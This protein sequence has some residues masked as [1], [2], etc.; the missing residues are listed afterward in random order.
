MSGIVHPQRVHSLTGKPVTGPG[1]VLWWV[2]REMRARDNWGLLHA[3]DLA[4]ERGA[5]VAACF[6]LAPS[7]LGAGRRHYDFL[8]GGLAGLHQDLA[9]LN[10]PLLIRMGE[11]GKE[12]ATLAK[13][14]S[15]SAVVTDFDPL[16]PKRAWM[17]Q[18]AR[19]L[20]GLAVHEVDA[21]NVVPCR[22]VSDKR[23]YMAR[24]IRPKITRRLH[25]FLTPLPEPEPQSVR[26]DQADS[27]L[28]DPDVLAAWLKPN[29]AVP[30]VDW[31]T[32]GPR[33]AL[34]GL[35]DFLANR[36]DRYAEHKNDPNAQAVSRLSP[37]LHF[38][39]LSA[40]R[41]A[42][43]TAD[44]GADPDS[45]RSFLE[46][47]IVRREL[48]DNFC[49]HTPDYDLASGYPA[50]ARESLALHARDR[51][52]YLYS[53][54]D[55]VNAATHDPLWNAAQH[56]MAATGHMHGWLR[57]YWAKKILEWS[58]SPEAAQERCVRLNDHWSLDGRDS[59]GYAGIAWALGGVHD[60]AWKERPVFGKVRYMN[61]RGAK[62]KFD[63]DAFAAKWG[64]N[65]SWTGPRP[66]A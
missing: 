28:P 56:Q 24:T 63:V 3:L 59:N 40:Q 9:D 53:D 25:E 5:P 64:A 46:E 18:A 11:P 15:A 22:A 17:A 23:E 33:A 12:V 36:L 2:H 62:R 57:M 13:T 27:G 21:R 1:P 38:G 8:L 61:Y 37:W 55:L 45:V 39:H 7:F 14:L 49:L 6:C 30:P 34:A 47:L 58:P 26:L 32:S 44:S 31:I 51:R 52:E 10:I 43:E 54:D 42:L 50:W 66:R 35:R 41:V 65:A 19:T 4:K 20:S 16:R 29:E 48:A 60:Q